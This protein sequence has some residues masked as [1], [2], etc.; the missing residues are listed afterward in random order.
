MIRQNITVKKVQA[1]NCQEAAKL[2]NEANAF[3]CRITIGTEQ[4]QLSAK[5]LMGVLALDIHYG[6]NLILTTDGFEEEAA[7]AALLNMLA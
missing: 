6:S 3:P 5:S 2:V 4:H 1:L 7:A